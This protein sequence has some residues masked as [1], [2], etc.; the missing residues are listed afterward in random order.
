MLSHLKTVV[1]RR[2]K[3]KFL[4]LLR[5]GPR[6]YFRCDAWAKQMEMSVASLPIPN[7]QSS[8]TIS[9][10]F[11][12]GQRFWYQTAYCAWTLAK[13]SKCKIELNLVD[14]GSLSEEY[15]SRLRRLFPNGIT[16][17]KTSVADRINDLLPVSKFPVLRNR[18]NDY[19]NI[20]KLIDVH[21]GSTGTKL[22]LDSDMLFFGR[23]QHLMDWLSKP[24]SLCLMTDCQESYGYTRP[25]ME[26][27]CG[28]TI[29]EKLNV[30]ICGLRSEDLDWQELEHWCQQ[31]HAAEGT[32][33]YLEQ[34]LVA[35][36][37]AR[38]NSLS[39][40]PPA[41]Y[42]TF[43]TE[44]QVDLKAGVLQHYVADSKPWYFGKAWKNLATNV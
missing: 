30:G 4:R 37:A 2:P 33:Y 36:L 31:L 8:E 25:L 27:L 9:C 11:L 10:W 18:W 3:D 28:E 1:Y 12:T 41:D 6:A 14:D 40:M 29:P 20:R 32:S 35:M 43:P 22:V 5:W 16:V 38:S 42:I 15:E 19:I 26:S 7:G 39:V 13:H 24:T 34:A 21:L 23:P 44:E 17:N